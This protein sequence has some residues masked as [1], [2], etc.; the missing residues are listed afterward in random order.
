[1]I[2]KSSIK[3]TMCVNCANGGFH[4]EQSLNEG[5]LNKDWVNFM[6]QTGVMDDNAVTFHISKDIPHQHTKF[7]NRTIKKIDR[8][9]DINVRRTCNTDVADIL[10]DDKLNY[11][12]FGPD[13]SDALGLAYID[14]TNYKPN[15]TWL[16][17]TYMYDRFNKKGK[18]RL[19]K[20]TK[21]VIVHEMLHTMGLSHP[22]GVG[23]YEGVDNSD[24][25]M[26]YNFNDFSLKHPM[27]GA[28]VNALQSLWN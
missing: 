6:K 23:N 11:D 20:I 14:E 8:N 3:Q 25:V 2:D 1:M 22:F 5:L 13:Y 21:H 18:V 10:I 12:S 4:Q 24:T 28:D 27:R 19:G 26:S 9:L 15:A 16:T 7:I 17:S